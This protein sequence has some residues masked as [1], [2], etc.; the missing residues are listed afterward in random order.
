MNDVIL[1]SYLDFLRK[2]SPAMAR[3][4]RRCAEGFVKNGHTTLDEWKLQ[5][6]YEKVVMD[7]L[8][9]INVNL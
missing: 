2:P 6:K 3:Q 4:I 7:E 5:F 8:N 9:K 1:D